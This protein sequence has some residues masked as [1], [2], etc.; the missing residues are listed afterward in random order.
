M[1]ITDNVPT[2]YAPICTVK[3]EDQDFKIKNVEEFDQVDPDFN[4]IA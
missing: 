2:R 3:L 4:S 1:P